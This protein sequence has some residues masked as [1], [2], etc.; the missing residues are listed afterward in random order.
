M[1]KASHGA[2]WASWHSSV[3]LVPSSGAGLR[4]SRPT[5][6]GGRLHVRNGRCKT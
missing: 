4:T 3:V 6:F 1:N 2:M 5:N